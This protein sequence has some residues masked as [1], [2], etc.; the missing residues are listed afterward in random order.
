[1]KRARFIQSLYRLINTACVSFI[2]SRI[3]S[4]LRV[5]DR[6][7]I[8]C[9]VRVVFKERMWND[10]RQIRVIVIEV[11]RDHHE[12]YYDERERKDMKNV[13]AD[14]NRRAPARSLVLYH[15]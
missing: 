5:V 14:C 10:V 4:V 3:E 13:P 15:E 2:H 9:H 6:I 8:L 1:M 11:A 12:A 7:E